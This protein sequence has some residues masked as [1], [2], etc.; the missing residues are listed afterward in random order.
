MKRSIRVER[1][2]AKDFMIFVST[3][4]LELISEW[5]LNFP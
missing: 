5:D 4:K 1:V 2:I 3:A